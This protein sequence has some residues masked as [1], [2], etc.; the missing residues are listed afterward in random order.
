MSSSAA[1]TE[2]V[3]VD[4]LQSP[5]N[6]LPGSFSGLVLR[7][8][9]SSKSPLSPSKNQQKPIESHQKPFI[10]PL[11]ACHGP[12]GTEADRGLLWPNGFSSTLGTWMTTCGAVGCL[13]TTYG[14]RHV[15]GSLGHLAELLRDWLSSRKAVA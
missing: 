6:S 10:P 13:G 5:S 11:S 1:A 2:S 3:R 7:C 4:H 14:A 8:L 12:G 15:T 9:H